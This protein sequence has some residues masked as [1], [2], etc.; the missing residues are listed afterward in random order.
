MRVVVIGGDRCRCWEDG[1]AL[2]GV[3]MRRREWGRIT[4]RASAESRPATRGFQSAFTT[5]YAAAVSGSAR[6][7]PRYGC[8]GVLPRLLSFP[9]M[10]G[11]ANDDRLKESTQLAT[12]DTEGVDPFPRCSNCRGDP[13]RRST[14]ANN[15]FGS[16]TVL[17][18]TTCRRFCLS[19]IMWRLWLGRQQTFTWFL[20]KH[21]LYG[22]P[23]GGCIGRRRKHWLHP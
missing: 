9:S 21:K 7:A 15:G 6:S 23:K 20:M 1:R 13:W 3:K 17:M 22:K 11:R 16:G 2:A 18:Q 10:R 12:R 4:P 19:C 5:S 14:T 8:D